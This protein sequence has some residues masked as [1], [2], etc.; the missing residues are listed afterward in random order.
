VLP[1]EAAACGLSECPRG[2][3]PTQADSRKPMRAY[4]RHSPPTTAMGP[5]TVLSL[6]M[7]SMS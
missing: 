5:P 6:Q 4:R 2:L 3:T 1:P 7:S